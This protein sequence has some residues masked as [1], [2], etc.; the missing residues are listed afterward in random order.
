MWPISYPSGIELQHSD[1]HE[2]FFCTFGT[3]FIPRADHLSWSIVL[4]FSTWQRHGVTVCN[5][6]FIKHCDVRAYRHGLLFRYLRCPQRRTSH[7]GLGRSTYRP[8]EMYCIYCKTAAFSSTLTTRRPL[9]R[10]ERVRH[11]HQGPVSLLEY[12]LRLKG[13][14]E[15][16]GPSNDTVIS[17]FTI[18][19]QDVQSVVSIMRENKPAKTR[20]LL[21]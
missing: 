5:H 17:W 18:Q 4:C 15:Q 14:V 2:A 8:T 11:Q 21:R 19:Y 6:Y 9:Q 3:T 1:A 10:Y 16:C 7:W 12:S 20:R 13:M